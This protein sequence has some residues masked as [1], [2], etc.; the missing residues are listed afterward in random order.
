MNPITRLAHWIGRPG[1]LRRQA[2]KTTDAAE[3]AS[4]LA[5]AA[6]GST[7]AAVHMEAAAA[8]AQAGRH[9]DAAASWRR[10]L[11]LQPLRIP[12]DAQLAALEP[13]MPHVAQEVLDAL[14]SPRKTRRH[15][16]MERRGTLDGEE[17]WRM[18]QETHWTFGELMPTLRYIAL[19]VAHTCGAPGR[20]RIDCDR[21]ER[22]GDEDDRM[23]QMGEAI[24]TWDGDRGITSVRVQE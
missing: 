18:E 10:S 5:Q 13:V 17:R 8:L 4:L 20:L 21:L 16:K 1:R 6:E 22:G 3:R 23:V 12:T 9:A 24:A 14:V 19:A 15:W 11:D 7:D 2:R